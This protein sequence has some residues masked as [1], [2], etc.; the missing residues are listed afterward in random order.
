MDK[1]EQLSQALV[2]YIGKGMTR[3]PD[4]DLGR[5]VSRWGGQMAQA[6]RP[7]L[8]LLLVE[9]HRLPVDWSQHD[10]VSGSEAATAMMRE[11]HPELTEAALQA[12]GW[13][14]SFDWR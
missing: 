8:D 3:A 5:V 4:L 14:Y 13:K 2:V 9:M 6:M 1:D 11:R 10:L 12:L 7:R